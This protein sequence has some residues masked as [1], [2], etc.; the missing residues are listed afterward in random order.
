MPCL[1]SSSSVK[2]ISAL[3]VNLCRL[4]LALT[5]ILSGFVKAIDPLG[6]QYKIQDYLSALSMPGLL[7]DWMT[8]TMSIV[9]SAL[10]FSLGIFLLFAIHRRLVSRLTLALMAIMTVIS[11]WLWIADPIS[12]CGC[13]GDAV[14]LTNGQ[15]LL[16]NLVL[17]AA[18]IVVSRYA[19]QMV[20][21]ISRTNQGIV[22]NYTV[23]F[24][25]ATSVY[26]LY[27]LPLFDFRPY[28]VGADIRKGMEIPDSAEQPQFE[29]TFIM[30]KDGVRP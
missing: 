18:A 19:L 8:L 10:E 12:D 28:H 9:L 4:V 13:F 29:T 3:L 17:L 26:C 15:T 30:E 27:D 7:P 23:V 14:H 24:I 22:I 11:L 2:K 25:V 21:F 1:A 16:K 20:R 5:L 6:T